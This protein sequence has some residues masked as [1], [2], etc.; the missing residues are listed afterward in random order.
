MKSRRG[1]AKE[2]CKTI[3]YLGFSRHFWGLAIAVESRE[4]CNS[5]AKWVDVSIKR[6]SSPQKNLLLVLFKSEPLTQVPVLSSLSE[7]CSRFE[8]L[9]STNF[10]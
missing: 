9:G 3:P 2:K 8:V 5:P 6:S 10:D 1:G 7:K 4:I